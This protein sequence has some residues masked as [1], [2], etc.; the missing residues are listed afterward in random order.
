MDVVAQLKEIVEKER[1]AEVVPFLKSLSAQDRKVLAKQQ[2]DFAFYWE[3]YTRERKSN[4]FVY[5]ETVKPKGSDIQKEILTLTALVCLS[6]KAFQANWNMRGILTGKL[7]QEVLPWYVPSWFNDFINRIDKEGWTGHTLEYGT[8]VYLEQQGYCQLR[9]EL[10]VKKMPGTVLKSI[11]EEM[12]YQPKALLKYPVTLEQ[13]LWYLF[14]YESD[15]HWLSPYSNTKGLPKEHVWYHALKMY[16]DEGRIEQKRLLPAVLLASNKNFNKTSSGWFMGLFMHLEPRPEELIEM[17]ED[18]MS[19]L[20]SPHSKVVNTSLKLIKG[21]AAHA[22]FPQ[23]D[24]MDIAGV[25]L[26][27]ETKSIINS[28]LMILDKMAKARPE[29][30]DRACQSACQALISPDGAVQVRAA[31]LILKY[32]GEEKQPIQEELA[33][34][35]AELLSEAKTLLSDLL[36]TE[37]EIDEIEPTTT[38]GGVELGDLTPF[39]TINS[40]DDLVFFASQAFDHQEDYH[41]DLLPQALLDLREELVNANIQKLEPAFQRAFKLQ[42]DEWPTGIGQMDILLAVF[43]LDLG[44]WLNERGADGVKG[45]R[46]MR[47]GY[48]EKD[49]MTA[50]G[51][52]WYAPRLNT[53]YDWNPGESAPVGYIV[54]EKL[55]YVVD[56]MRRDEKTPLLSTPTHLPCWIDPKVLVDRLKVYQENRAKPNEAD[57]EIAVSRCFS[58]SDIDMGAY[59]REHL[60]GE[61]QALFLYLYNDGPEYKGILQQP[62]AWQAAYHNLNQEPTASD[63]EGLYFF[64]GDV[65]H[66]TTG[67]KWETRK[68]TIESK[69]YDYQEGKE[70]PFS[71]DQKELSTSFEQPTEPLR[72]KLS[73]F[74]KKPSKLTSFRKPLHASMEFKVAW[75]SAEENDIGRFISL[76]PNNPAAV[77]VVLIQRV[78]KW[79][80]I[81]EESAKRLAVKS[82]EYLSTIWQPYGRIVH[83]FL[84][85]SMMSSEK[86]ARIIAGEIWVNAVMR[87]QVDQ[88]HIGSAIARLSHHEYATLKRFTDLAMEIYAVSPAHKAAMYQ[89]LC[90]CIR[91]MHDQPVK[92]LKALLT[93]LREV[94]PQTADLKEDSVLKNRLEHWHESKSLKPLIDKLLG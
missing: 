7:L 63:I 10:V 49:V 42:M 50:A 6:Q 68:E 51:S 45:F 14:E 36:V 2:K 26:T 43:F 30:H 75:L 93:I 35:G 56:K 22:K 67:F 74:L 12:S 87:D 4:G 88:E 19:V 62:R 73:F 23:E 15:I 33:M 37:A 83:E 90:A 25:L 52:S 20:H 91:Y 69:R 66:Y 5:T 16:M 46:E 55:I 48:M 72:K 94:K 17:S 89:L 27:H 58:R 41:F 70:V 29:L 21:I 54:K 59:A 34:Y 40:Y 1:R 47:K 8:L 38:G 3:Y 86:T 57:M 64:K 28:T 82:L 13:H 81:P 53:L 77:L 32:V 71:Y 44:R 79:P 9:P 78:Y 31:K 80:T 39:P 24:F 84:G 65:K 18:L 85:F 60:E 11:G 76:V 92:N 61:L